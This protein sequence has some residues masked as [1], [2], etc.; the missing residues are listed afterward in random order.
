MK[1]LLIHNMYKQPGG[2]NSIFQSEGELLSRYGH[3]VERLVFDNGKIKTILDQC[4]SALKIIY[5]PAS[6]RELK[7]KIES[8]NPDIIHVHNFVPIASPA[9]FFVAKRYAIPVIV[10]LHNYRLI[11]PSVTLF[12]KQKIYEKSIN[13][14]FPMDAIL[15]G[16]YRNSRIQTAVVAI[17][18][19]VHNL[20]GTWKDKIDFYITLSNFAREKFK[21]STLSIPEGKLLV[22]PNFVTDCGMGDSV[23]QDYFLY[24]GRLVEEKG[25]QTLLDAAKLYNF[26]LTLIGDGPLRGRVENAARANPNIRCLG[27]LDK[28][29]IMSHMKKCKALILPSLWYEGFPLAMLEAFSSGTVV[30]ASKLGS[31]AEIIE[32][33]VNSL[34]FEAGNAKDL[35]RRI[36]EIDE[37][38]EWAKCLADNARL[39][40]LTHYTPEKNYGLLT[41]IYKQASAL[42]RQEQDKMFHDP[43]PQM[44][45]RKSSEYQYRIANQGWR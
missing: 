34:L 5:N 14:I 3:F 35:V 27:F 8:F 25:I 24:V 39:S 10:T 17:M 2:E 37:E 23:R 36:V 26:K 32:N 42:K 21:Q 15:K 13:S 41:N 22:K 28:P 45:R 4:L 6:A 16:V 29:T 40:Y 18:V 30:I 9:I 31:M 11:C 44:H 19:T 7:K 12:H 43:L 33:R 20:I 38:P 1:I